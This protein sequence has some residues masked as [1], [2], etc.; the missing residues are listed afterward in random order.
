MKTIR[1]TKSFDLYKA[2]I[3]SIRADLVFALLLKS[4]TFL[5]TDYFFTTSRQ[6]T[7]YIYSIQS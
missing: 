5:R 7:D 2:L 6:S 4:Q 3:H 1:V